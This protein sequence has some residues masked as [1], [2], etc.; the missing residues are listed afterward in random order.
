MT[1]Q[2]LIAVFDR[3]VRQNGDRTCFRFV[4][5]GNWQSLTWFEVKE[6]VQ[7]IAG[8]LRRLGLTDGDRVC[9]FSKTCYEWTLADLGIMAAL[10]ISVPIYE[11]NTAEQAKF[12]IED[13][14]AKVIFVENAQQLEMITSIHKNL[15]YLKQIIIFKNYPSSKKIE[16][17]YTLDELMLLGLGDGLTI[18]QE[19]IQKLVPHFEATIVY[20]SGTTGN[21]KG[22]LLTQKNIL[23]ELEAFAKIFSFPT[24]FESLLFLPLAHIIARVVQYFQISRGFIQC[25]AEG[26]DK[27]LEN[28]AI[29]RPHF[30]ASVPRIFEK[31]YARTMQSVSESSSIKKK[32]FAWATSVGLRVAKLHAE[33]KPISLSLMLQNAIAHR[34]IFKKLH[35]K[36]GGRIAF[37]ISG[38]APLSP[39]IAHFFCAFGFKILEGYGLTETTAAIALNSENSFKIGAVG[40]PVSGAEIKIAQDGEILVRGGMVFKGYYKNDK[41]T[42]EAFADGGWFQ[43]GDIGVIDADGFLKIT[44]RKKDIIVTAGGKNIAPQNIENL[45]K[46]DPYFSQVVVHG[47]RRKFLSALITLNREEILKFAQENKISYSS[48]NELVTN[49]KIYEFIRKRLDEKNARLAQYETI[50]KF[51]ILPEDFTIENGTLT[52]TLKVRRKMIAQ[53]FQNILDSFYR[54]ESL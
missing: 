2:N 27:L 7:N 15:P 8:G 35:D 43:T 22:A 47:D 19:A 25:Y 52:P 26:V 1:E 17:I 50:K 53:K 14:G 30:M 33:K 39:E 40:K 48:Y 31:I 16:G 45:I 4:E 44:D 28:I 34:L 10:G 54:E 9:I 3:S 29:V 36:L 42:R 5:N 49:K 20:T 18:Y 12:V 46:E 41:A 38:G 51:A 24:Y 32:I 11:S 23:A 13:S 6:R 21:P 37:I